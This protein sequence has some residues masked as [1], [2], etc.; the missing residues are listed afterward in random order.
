[1]LL[2]KSWIKM[3]DCRPFVADR[4]IVFFLWSVIQARIRALTSWLLVRL[5]VFHRRTSWI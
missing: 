5:L 2:S 4:V 3:S 1:L